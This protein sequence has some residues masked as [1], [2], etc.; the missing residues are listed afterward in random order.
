VITRVCASGD[1]KRELIRGYLEGKSVL[2]RGPAARGSTLGASSETANLG[3][4]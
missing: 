2:G 1:L 3:F 4:Q